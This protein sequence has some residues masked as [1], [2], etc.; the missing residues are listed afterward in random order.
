MQVTARAGLSGDDV[1]G[2]G[3]RL[4]VAPVGTGGVVDGPAWDVEDFPALGS[5]QRDQQCGTARVQIDGPG[6]RLALAQLK[7]L[8]DQLEQSRLVVGHPP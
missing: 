7:E 5:Q 6:H 8:T 4:A 1:G 2:L 3:V